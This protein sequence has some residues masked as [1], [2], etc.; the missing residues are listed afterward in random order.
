MKPIVVVTG[1][2]GQ[3]GWELQQ[4]AA[5]FEHQYQFIFTDRTQLDLSDSSS[6]HPFFA[7][8][9][10]QYFINCAAYT[11][12]D[13]AETERDA[14][15]AINAT[16]VGDIATCCNEFDCKLIT[17]S[18]DYV[19]NGNGTS[20]YKTDTPTDPVNFYGATK[21]M[22]EQLAIRN[23]PS[24]VIIR[25]SWV[26]S[27]HGHNFVKTMLRLMKDRSE[28][29]VVNDQQGCPTYA[30][31]LA[32]AIMHIVES[33]RKGNHAAGIFHYSNVGDI[34]WF[35]FAQ[36]IQAEAKL[37]CKVL[38]IPS[39]AFPTPAKRPGYS[40][41][42]TASIATVFGV[43]MKP[44]RKQLQICLSKILSA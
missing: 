41:M 1:K 15:M 14:A 16:V 17:I 12:V 4:L 44:W 8:I 30:A 26:Y 25:T 22:G 21:A 6:I 34:T 37:D 13:K 38:P 18:T 20:P 23:N 24:T 3:L 35:Q 40:V 36:A 2:N 28:I 5:F 11:A 9:K 43:A 7:S 29:S 10:P 42:D 19:F 31:D 32:E 39:T 33:H 27:T